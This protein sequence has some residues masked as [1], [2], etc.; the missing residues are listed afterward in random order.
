MVLEDIQS[1]GLQPVIGEQKA[2]QGLTVPALCYGVQFVKFEPSGL[3]HDSIAVYVCVSAHVLERACQKKAQTDT[4]T[5]M[6]ATH[7]SAAH[8]ATSTI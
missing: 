1:N 3:D 5:R 2:I 4:D 6:G 7:S 8:T